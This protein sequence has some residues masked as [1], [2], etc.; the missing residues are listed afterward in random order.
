MTLRRAT[1]EKRRHIRHH[2]H[3]HHLVI[4]VL[5]SSYAVNAWIVVIAMCAMK[6]AIVMNYANA[7]QLS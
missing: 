2:T 4:V 6:S 1:K 3:R 5:L 7:E